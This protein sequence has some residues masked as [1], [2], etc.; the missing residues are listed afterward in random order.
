[1]NEHGLAE[2][3]LRASRRQ[4]AAVVSLSEA[5]LQ[6]GD[7]ASLIDRTP[8]LVL[9]TLGVEIC[10]LFE[11]A[12][13][14]QSLLLRAG[15]GWDQG[16]VG[17]LRLKAGAGSHGGFTLLSRQPVVFESL[18]RERRFWRSARLFDHQVVSGA[19]V[20]IGG[21]S[22]DFGVLS[23]FSQRPRR[24]DEDDVAFLQSVA[25]IIG[26]GV[27][28]EAKRKTLVERKELLRKL[29]AGDAA[30]E[31]SRLKSAFLANTS[32]EIRTPLNIILGYNEL[33][34]EQLAE[35]GCS[36]LA[37]YLDAVQRAGH[38]LLHTVEQILDFSKVE[39]GALE[40]K[41]VEISLAPLLENLVNDFRVLA[42]AKD[43]KLSCAV[44]A[45]GARV[46]FDEH[47]LAGALANLLQ[48]AVKF[49]EHGLVAARLFRDE[50]GTLKIEIRDSGIGIDKSYM[51]HL[52]EPFSQED[53]SYSRRFEGA[54]LG[55]VL[56][57]K[58]LELNRA[59]LDVKSTKGEGTICT[60]EF[61]AEAASRVVR[62][63]RPDVGHA[64]AVDFQQAAHHHP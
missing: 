59:T 15:A 6:G 19:A 1:M 36:E 55:L 23:V 50:T 48:N 29:V 38:R 61:Q 13:D 54:G 7:L 12:K 16:L 10:S 27:E 44:E 11:L 35:R 52:F 5:A 32:H 34:A 62:N 39:T 43:L 20:V 45:P 53:S 2:E 4:Q 46:R 21:G 9:Q 37:P 8:A 17:R 40:L 64:G 56:T 18:A 51:P 42:V 3:K 26:L 63:D 49:T 57:R 31:A 28:R 30:R 25:R 58:F 14:G 24:F 47:C 41:P 22:P 33:I 60:I